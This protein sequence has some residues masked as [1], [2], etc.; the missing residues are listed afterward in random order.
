MHGGAVALATGSV[1]LGALE[2]VAHFFIDLAKCRNMT[3][4]G[5]DQVIHLGCKALWLG[6]WAASLGPRP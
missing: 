2:T 4:P 1:M 6:L 5:Q 3:N